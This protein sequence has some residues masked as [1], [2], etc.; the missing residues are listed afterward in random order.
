MVSASASTLALYRLTVE[1]GRA[2]DDD[3]RGAGRRV[4]VVGYEVHQELLRA[5]RLGTE[6]ALRIEVDGSLFSVVGVLARKPMVGHTTSTY[7]WDRKVLIPE[8]TYDVL[9]APAHDA[10]RIYV[11]GVPRGG[12]RETARA[13]MRAVL[14]RRHLGVRNFD[15]EKDESGGTEDL[16]MNVIQ[17]L[18]VGTG[19]LA[20]LAS[21]INIMNVM[22]VTVAERTREIGL[23]RALGA[24]PRTILVQF[25]LEATMLSLIGALAGVIAGSAMAWI[26]ALAARAQIGSW[27]LV[28]PPWSIALG[29]GL[30]VVTGL[31]FGILPAWRAARVS[32][33]DALRSDG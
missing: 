11:R 6:S 4:C 13:T 3:D 21:G 24:T 19:V 14:L 17:I 15:L 31:V 12:M 7:A 30:A 29:L 32:P 5:A 2:L 22:L 10:S 28:I 16:I 1:H 26:T 27:E 8:T 18:L 9:Y 25:L 23:R 33:I 20:L